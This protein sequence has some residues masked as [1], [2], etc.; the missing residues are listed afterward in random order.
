MCLKN[1]TD[2]GLFNGAIYEPADRFIDGDNSICILIDCKRRVI[3]NAVFRGIPSALDPE[4]EAEGYFDYGYA[5]TCHKPQGSE[6]NSVVLIDEYRG[7]DQRRQWLYTG[8]S[9]G[10]QSAS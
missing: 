10:Q 9:A 8:I 4:D 3:P 2:Y 1:N 7:S 5:F 6:F